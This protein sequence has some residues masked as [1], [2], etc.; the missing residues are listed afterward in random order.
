MSWP[1]IRM[2]RGTL[3]RWA[4][5]LGPWPQYIG[6][7]LCLVDSLLREERRL[8]VLSVDGL[9]HRSRCRD[10]AHCRR[11]L[12]ALK[13]LGLATETESGIRLPF[14]DE[15]W[16]IREDRSALKRDNAKGAGRPRPAPESAATGPK[17]E[18]IK[19]N[20]NHTR[21][22]AWRPL[23]EE[24]EEREREKELP[25]LPPSSH[26]AEVASIAKQ[27]TMAIGPDRRHKGLGNEG[28]GAGSAEEADAVAPPPPVR[29]SAALLSSELAR[30]NSTHARGGARSHR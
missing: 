4:E 3:E 16:D 22:T 27:A 28:S 20:H 5:V 9:K 24:E 1:F 25:P 11:F 23:A 14:V 21:A 10:A 29:P 30:P 19:E 12:D 26:R 18:N 13:N 2:P 17:G 8:D 7:W 6:P 15:A